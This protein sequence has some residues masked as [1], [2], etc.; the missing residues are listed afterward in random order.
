MYT[1]YLDTWLSGTPIDDD[2]SD[3]FRWVGGSLFCAYADIDGF[4]E[5][6]L[7]I[8]PEIAAKKTEMEMATQ[9][10]GILNSESESDNDASLVESGRTRKMRI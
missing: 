7:A 10:A 4:V 6:V 3:I 9:I 5:S 1:C 2:G 8:C